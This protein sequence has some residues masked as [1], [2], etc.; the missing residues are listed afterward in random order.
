MIPGTDDDLYVRGA[1]TLLASW[2]EY[3]H[4]CADAALE[5][6]NGVSAAVFPSGPERAVYNNAL[7]DRGLGPAVRVAAVDAM[8]AAYRCARVDR[9]AAW[10][11]ESDEGMR[12]EL[13]RRGFTIDESTRAMGMSLTDAPLGVAEFELGPSDWAEHLRIIGAPPG[14]LSGADPRAFHILVARFDGE[15]V[16]AAMAFDHNGDC[17]VFNMGTLEAARRRGIGTALAA[18]HVRDA[19]ERGCTTAS[20][21]STTMAERVYARV[22]FRD[23]GR[24]LEYVPR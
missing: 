9:Y 22:G 17:G 24:I 21:Q 19:I 13:S 6:L 20:L 18:R 3:A 15:P 1:A 16:A 8:E 11:H 5:R 23:L 4:G 14:L 10:V 7:L 2:E 12:A